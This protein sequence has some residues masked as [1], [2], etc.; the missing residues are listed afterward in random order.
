MFENLTAD[1]V[2]LEQLQLIFLQRA[3]AALRESG[4]SDDQIDEALGRRNPHPLARRPN[5]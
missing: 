1:P 3:V 4:M 5:P 2:K